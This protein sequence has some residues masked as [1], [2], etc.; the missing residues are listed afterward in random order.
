VRSYQ[1]GDPLRR[2]H[3]RATSRHID[4]P[5]TTEFEQERIAD[6]GIILD[7]RP[8]QMEEGG[9][10]TLFEHGVRAAAALADA[11][12]R[13]GHRVG[14]LQYGLG[15]WVFPGYGRLQRE[16]ILRALAIS[17]PTANRIFWTLA[18]FPTRFFP[19]RSQLLFI[20][21]LQEEDETTLL[22][23]CAFGY[24]VIV[25]SPDPIALRAEGLPQNG[26]LPMAVRLA[27][28][29]RLLLLKRLRQGGVI[30]INWPIS[31]NLDRVVATALLRTPPIRRIRERT[32]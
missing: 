30:P 4:I 23:L 14:L 17:K 25:V 22:R 6:V 10:T 9:D 2:I 26:T 32:R 7:T 11:L 27:R 28:L 5:Y 24:S 3:W 21:S 18:Q 29:E 16:R 31:E 19:A 12:L 20:S 1:P 15:S 8:E 13:D